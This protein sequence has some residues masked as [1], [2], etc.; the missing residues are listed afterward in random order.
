MKGI[1]IPYKALTDVN[2]NDKEKI[3]DSMSEYLSK[4]K[5]CTITNFKRILCSYIGKEENILK[6]CFL[7][8]IIFFIIDT[9]IHFIFENSIDWQMVIAETIIYFVISFSFYIVSK[10]SKKDQK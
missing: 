10:N 5:E 8:G 3:V 6:N 2:L 1:W 9:L 4:E 7:G